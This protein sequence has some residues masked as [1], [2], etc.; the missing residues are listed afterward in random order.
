ML[1]VQ[2]EE[3]ILKLLGKFQKEKKN[4]ICKKNMLNKE[5]LRKNKIK[6]KYQSYYYIIIIILLNISSKIKIHSE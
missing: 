2:S 3:I 6:Q 4:Y 1:L 5:L